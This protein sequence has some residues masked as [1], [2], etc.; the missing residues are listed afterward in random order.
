MSN[1]ATKP[2]PRVTFDEIF[3]VCIEPRDASTIANALRLAA[4][5]YTSFATEWGKQ[6]RHQEELA[7][8]EQADP[9]SM[10]PSAEASR[11]LAKQFA[12]QAEEAL[13]LADELEEVTI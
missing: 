8:L 7:R 5:Q 12:H 6:A 3:G 4:D 2:A 11:R 13:A 1:A 10:A 9:E